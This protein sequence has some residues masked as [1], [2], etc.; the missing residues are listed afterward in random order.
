MLKELIKNCAVEDREK[1]DYRKFFKKY[2]PS[3]DLDGVLI[4]SLDYVTEI[5]NN[6]Y[7]T[8]Y[9]ATDM[10]TLGS[11]KDWLIGMGYSEDYANRKN[12]EYWY[13]DRLFQAPL[14]TG[15]KEFLEKLDS[16]GIPIAV[17]SSRPE[18]LKSGT[19]EV[20]MKNLPFLKEENIFIQDNSEM[21][22]D[23]YKAFTINKEN[24]GI[25][26]E[27]MHIHAKAVLDYTDSFIG[28]MSNIYVL[29]DPPYNERIIR[30]KGR[31]YYQLPD[32][33][34]VAERFNML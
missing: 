6:E 27:D 19:T 29:S 25:H 11:V 15:A 1:F 32:F 30:F 7:G 17:I 24:I 10:R 14:K 33:N 26:F 23:I 2:K 22:G 20:L 34:V 18:N 31:T 12:Y 4:D 5:F 3:F 8:N 28:L 9:L 13:G 21:T 16:E